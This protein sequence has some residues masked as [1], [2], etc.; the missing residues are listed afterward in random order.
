MTMN[1]APSARISSGAYVVAGL[2]FVPLLGVA[3][4]LAAIIWGLLSSRPGGRTVATMGAAGIAFTVALYGA[5]FYLGFAQRG[6]LYDDLRAKLAQSNLD[7]SVREIEFYRLSNGNYPDSLE[8]VKTSAGHSVAAAELLDPRVMHGQMM[9]RL[10]Y[11]KKIDAD[12]YYLRA[13]G[14]DG[15]PFS[16]GSLGPE[17]SPSAK[18]GL[19]AAPQNPQ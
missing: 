5:L 7:A 11:Y 14:D 16:P 19:V 10:F 17:I 3:F 2:S 15:R 4:G 6:G 12:H 9:P 13:V 1:A 18:L 8:D